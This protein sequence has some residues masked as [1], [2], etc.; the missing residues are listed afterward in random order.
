[1]TVRKTSLYVDLEDRKHQV[2]DGSDQD[3]AV[4]ACWAHNSE[5]GSSKLLLLTPEFCCAVIFLELRNFTSTKT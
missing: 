4:E 3:G 2:K 1:M 5:A